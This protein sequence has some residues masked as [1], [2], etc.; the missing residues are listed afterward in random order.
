MCLDPDL[1]E[2]RYDLI[3]NCLL[4][5]YCVH[6]LERALLR[7]E[8][9]AQPDERNED[10]Q[11]Q[12]SAASTPNLFCLISF[13]LISLRLKIL[14]VGEGLLRDKITFYVHFMSYMFWYY[15]HKHAK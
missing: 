5:P 1:R 12:S 7:P 11:S 2:P 6:I 9:T 15:K 14:K 13:C 4:Q 3:A 8:S 10:K